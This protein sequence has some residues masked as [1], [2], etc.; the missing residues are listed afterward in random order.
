MFFGRGS[1]S[2]RSDGDFS[3]L[4][5][6]IEAMV[7]HLVN[8]PKSI[9]VTRVP[10][11][12]GGVVFELRVAKEDVG[13]VIGKKGRTASAMRTLLSA[14]SRRHNLTADLQIIE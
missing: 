5:E 2:E 10:N 7:K 6:L 12:D 3:H 13:K 8:D 11:P 14:A 1:S 9:D 4:Q